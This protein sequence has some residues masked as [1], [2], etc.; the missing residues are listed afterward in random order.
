RI[1]S[2]APRDA[3]RT[4]LTRDEHAL[5]EHAPEWLDA[6]VATGRYADASRHYRFD[7]GRELVLPL[8][9]R[10]GP[11]G[12]GGWLLSHPP[13]W[14]IGG[15][16]GDADSASVAEVITDLRRMSAHR[17]WVRPDP[18]AADLWAGA[19]ALDGSATVVP[20]RA[21]IVDL[22]GGFD[23]VLARMPRA[24][25]KYMRRAERAGVRV[26]IGYGGDMLH[27][28]DVLYRK[29]VDR[30]AKR[31]HEPQALARWRAGRRDPVEK[32][33]TMARHLGNRFVLA[34][35]YVDDQ[36]AFS[37]LMLLGPTAHV[38]RS[39]MDVDLVGPTK[40]G[41]LV[42]RRLL[43]LACDAGCT[44]YHL[45]ESGNSESLAQFKE[46]LGAIAVDYA[47][48]RFERLPYTRADTVARTIVKKVLHFRDT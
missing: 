14:G 33:E 35:G 10:T 39:A 3:W 43:Q 42:H 4:A 8:V 38:T 22:S 1:I 47:E 13:A 12:L 48:Y 29:S 27:V 11:A 21:H 6:I 40:V 18:M 46:G 41:T 17:I 24:T 37:A 44:R 26:E 45:G 7:D 20:R 36:P 16:V 30:W 28:H 9:R 2:P 34:V 32:L 19:V 23:P 25:R 31:Q 15:L 5:P